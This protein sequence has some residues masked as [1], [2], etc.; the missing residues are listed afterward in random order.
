MVLNKEV[1]QIVKKILKNVNR[2]SCIGVL[3]LKYK[4]SCCDKEF[5]IKT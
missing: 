2:G 3:T 1:R 4:L 5:I